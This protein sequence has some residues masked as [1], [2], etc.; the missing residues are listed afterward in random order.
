MRLRLTEMRGP[1]SLSGILLRERRSPRWRRTA[2]RTK[3]PD[4]W[5]R[6]APPWIAALTELGQT[7]HGVEHSSRVDPIFPLAGKIRHRGGSYIFRLVT[8]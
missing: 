5:Y 3:P 7:V 1:G 2:W 4:G 8:V 6:K